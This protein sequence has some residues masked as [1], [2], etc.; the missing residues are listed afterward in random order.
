[1]R[2]ASAAKAQYFCTDYCPRWRR[3]FQTCLNHCTLHLQLPCTGTG[4]ILRRF[5]TVRKRSCGKVMFSQVCVKNSV[6]GGEVYTPWADTPLTDRHTPGKQ[7]PHWL[8]DRHLPPPC[9]LQRTVCILR[10][11]ILVHDYFFFNLWR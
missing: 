2:I 11:C 8:A 1:M 6:H 7:T 5:V 4:G 9:L 3:R 10:E